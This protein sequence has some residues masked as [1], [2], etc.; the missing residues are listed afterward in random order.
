MSGETRAE[1]TANAET[2]ADIVR[3]TLG[4]FGANKLVLDHHGNVTT[5]AAG[6]IV[7]EQIDITDPAVSLL[8][9]G[10]ID[11]GERYGDGTTSVVA[12]A[13]GLLDNAADLMAQGLHPTTIERGYRNALAVTKH[14][15]AQKARPVGDDSIASVAATAL[16]GTRDPHARTTV[17]T[18]IE[19]IVDGLPSAQFN[20]HRIKVTPRLGGG[21][22]ETELVN[23]LLIEKDPVA[24]GMPRSLEDVG[25]ALLSATVDLPRFGGD[26]GVLN[27]DIVLNDASFSDRVDLADHERRLFRETLDT[28]VDTGCRVIVT[29]TAINDRVKQEVANAGFLGFQHVDGD[30]LERLATV[31]GGR[32]VDDLDHITA[33]SLGWGD[34]TVRREAG[35]DM[36]VVESDAGDP[37]Y[38]LFCRAPDPRSITAFKGSVESAIAVVDLALDTGDV[39][40]GGGAIE[41]AL[42][43][44]L[45]DHARGV[46]SRDQLAVE[47][48]ADTLRIIPQTLAANAGL[49]GW[50]AVLQLQVAHA[51]GRET[52]GVDCFSG[53]LVDVVGLEDPLVE[54]R[55][56][57]AAVLEAAADLAIKLVRI[58]ERL[59]ATELNPEPDYE[60]DRA[61]PGHE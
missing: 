9:T 49:D 39:V 15:L 56:L 59:E 43:H 61:P 27:T 52:M 10:A 12:L 14:T 46:R 54:P 51:E 55:S 42:S 45:R 47:A 8:R 37:T 11:F 34:V 50:E 53:D 35:R 31:T 58:D 29:G 38:T 23:G 2:I 33:E 22:A 48:F 7:L 1:L 41:M 40:P 28:L 5:S 26:T 25:I 17:S 44:R 16:T 20:R 4:P 32:I 57:K 30:D 36:V 18:Y 60:E 3:T 6:S 24:E 19:Q 13:G 21:H